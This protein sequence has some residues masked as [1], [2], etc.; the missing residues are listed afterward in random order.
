MLPMLTRRAALVHAAFFPLMLASKV[1]TAGA[2]AAQRGDEK[3]PRERLRGL[4]D[5]VGGRLGVATLDTTSG[6]R[7]DQRANE[8]FPM[9]STFKFLAAAAVLARVDRKEDR[10]ERLV[11]FSKAD[12]LEYAPVAKARVAE[13]AMTLADLCDA[14]I[15]VSDNTAGNL[16]LS[17]IGGPAGLTA[18]V[19]S[20]GDVATRLDRTEPTLNEATPGDRRD[21][22]SPSAMLQNLRTLLLGDALSRQSRDRLTAWLV[23]NKTGNAL[24]RA[25]LPPGWKVGDKT[26]RGN[27]GTT[28]DIAIIWPPNRRPIL[29]AAYLTETTSAPPARDAMLADVARIVAASIPDPGIAGFVI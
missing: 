20:L 6:T 23:A 18:Y 2:S 11:P 7:L 9:C 26:G 29:V 21:T 15:T 1:G 8:P 24:L 10:L 19:R 5:K 13:G 3:V 28:N 4:E 27:Y 25:G 12:L 17:T 22:T 14:A 16:L